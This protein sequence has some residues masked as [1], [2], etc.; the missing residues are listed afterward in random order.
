[1][2]SMNSRIIF[3]SSKR[4]ECEISVFSPPTL[5]FSCF[6]VKC[7]HCFNR[8]S[9]HC[10]LDIVYYYILSNKIFEKCSQ[11]WKKKRKK[12]TSLMNQYNRTMKKK[13]FDLS[14][15]FMKNFK[16]YLFD[17]ICNNLLLTA[18]KKKK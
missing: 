17:G 10:R 9:F 4:A 18:Q 3:H 15:S 6:L 14:T 8:P 16:M 11:D 7:C 13:A 1:M 5:L 2:L 12:N